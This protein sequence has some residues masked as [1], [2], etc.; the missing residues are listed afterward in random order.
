MTFDFH[1]H[2]DDQSPESF[3]LESIISRDRVSPEDAIRTALRGMAIEQRAAWSTNNPS[4]QK[5]EFQGNRTTR[6]GPRAPLRTTKAQ[7][8]IGMFADNPRFR[9]SIDAVIASRG[10]RYGDPA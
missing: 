10:Q 1:I 7:E 9:E 5:T 4:T 2:I 8:V 6:R 3:L